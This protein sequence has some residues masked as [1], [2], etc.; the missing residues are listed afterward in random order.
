M[1]DSADAL[2][3][4]DTRGFRMLFR[5]S[6]DATLLRI[7]GRNAGGAG[8]SSSG[9]EQFVLAVPVDIDDL[10]VSRLLEL[11]ERNRTHEP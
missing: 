11:H 8:K 10:L 9:G 1:T 4:D 2:D 3:R 7:V 5:A 6:R